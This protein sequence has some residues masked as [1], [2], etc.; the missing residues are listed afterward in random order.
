VHTFVWSF[1][2]NLSAHAHA[3]PAVNF[4]VLVIACW[5]AIVA[6][7]IKSE[8]AEAKYIDFAVFS[9]SQGALTGIPVVVV[10][11]D[12]AKAFYLVLTFLIFVACTVVLSLIF[13][14]KM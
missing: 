7:D 5:Q 14:P 13:L 4:G 3:C 11:K 9:M 2:V 12:T 1:K 10:T 6:K 8:F